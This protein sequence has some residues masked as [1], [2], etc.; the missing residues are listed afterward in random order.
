MDLE[1]FYR[2]HSQDRNDACM[3]LITSRKFAESKIEKLQKDSTRYF[4]IKIKNDEVVY[5]VKPGMEKESRDVALKIEAEEAKIAILKGKINQVGNLFTKY[6]FEVPLLEEVQRTYTGM[7]RVLYTIKKKYQHQWSITVADPK[8]TVY[9]L[10]MQETKRLE[11]VLAERTTELQ[12][13]I[14][15]L[16]DLEREINSIVSGIELPEGHKQPDSTV[17]QFVSGGIQS[18]YILGGIP[19]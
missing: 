2:A 13:Q 11:K 6:S 9:D 12:P 4:T 18:S 19:R 10:R 17:E 3:R 16:K 8:S 7:A 14:K 15:A 5:T 1:E